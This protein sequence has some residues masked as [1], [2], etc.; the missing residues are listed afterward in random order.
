ML[1]VYVWDSS[2]LR[3]QIFYEETVYFHNYV[4][5]STWYSFHR[6]R[7]DERLSRPWSYT[8]ALTLVALDLESNVLTTRTLLQHG[9]QRF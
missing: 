2:A 3:L 7:K 9:I 1:L 8:V 6:P 4:S 5:R